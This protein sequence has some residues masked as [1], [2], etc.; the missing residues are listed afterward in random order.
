MEKV[1][2]L[3]TLF[4]SLSFSAINECKTDIYFGNGILTK[5]Q[6][7]K[8]NA[9]LLEETIKQKFGLDYYNKHIGNVD[10]AYNSTWDRS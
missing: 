7:A 3:L 5:Q 10:Y 6:S 4:A 9:Y 1:I 2:L 8:D